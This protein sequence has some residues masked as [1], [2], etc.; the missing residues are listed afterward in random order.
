MQS[1]QGLAVGRGRGGSQPSNTSQ[2]QRQLWVSWEK[3]W[4]D[5]HWSLDVSFPTDLYLCCFPEQCPKVGLAPGSQ[6]WKLSCGE[7]SGGQGCCSLPSHQNG[8]QP[9]VSTKHSTH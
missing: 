1:C 4:P 2:G 6:M 8:E 9:L 5:S 7:L 3:G